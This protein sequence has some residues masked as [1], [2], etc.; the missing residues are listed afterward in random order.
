MKYPK[1]IAMLLT[2]FMVPPSSIGESYFTVIGV[3][4]QKNPT[5]TPCINLPRKSVF[6]FGIKTKIPPTMAATLQIKKFS[7]NNFKCTFWKT[8]K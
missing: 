4:E 6:I 8:F 3:I 7:L 2:P 5:Q 1:E